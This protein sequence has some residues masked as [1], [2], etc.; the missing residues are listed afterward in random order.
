MRAEDGSTNNDEIPSPNDEVQTEYVANSED[1]LPFK[2][3]S[4]S[5]TS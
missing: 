5:Q 2:T 3:Q 4:N 1:G